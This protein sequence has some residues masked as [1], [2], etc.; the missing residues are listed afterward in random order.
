MSRS[1]MRYRAACLP[2]PCRFGRF[3]SALA[4]LEQL[5]AMGLRVPAF[6]VAGA[7]EAPAW[8]RACARCL[9][10]LTGRGCLA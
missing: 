1:P 5:E 4:L 9:C 8:G 7:V 3:D 2:S 10:P 6:L